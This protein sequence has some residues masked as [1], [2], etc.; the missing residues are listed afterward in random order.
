MPL[1]LPRL[2]PLYAK[3]GYETPA[4]TIQTRLAGAEKAATLTL[5]E[6]R[7]VIETAIGLPPTA[8]SLRPFRDKIGDLT[9]DAAPAA[10]ETRLLAAVTTLEAIRTNAASARL[11]VIVGAALFGGS[12]SPTE[13]P[14]FRELVESELARHQQTN[15]AVINALD[16]AG[17]FDVPKGFKPVQE[18]ADTGSPQALATA[19]SPVL[20][21]LVKHAGDVDERQRQQINLIGQRVEA[22]SE[23]MEMQWWVANGYSHGQTQLF[24][25][26]TVA[27]AVAHAAFDL[28]GMTRRPAGVFAAPTLLSRA[29]GPKHSQ[30]KVKLKELA[31]GV[32]IEQRK[33]WLSSVANIVPLLPV[34][35]SMRLALDA[36]DAADWEGR[37][38]REAKVEVDVQ[39]NAAEWANQMYLELMAARALG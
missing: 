37:L 33:A 6:L 34:L 5:A 14:Q 1:D 36:N 26:M 19:L 7:P 35:H 2:G 32:P 15:T 13:D 10:P 27:E 38:A 20:A 30:K 39:L 21:S 9:F 22:L 11:A 16:R 4:T 24:T 25:D 12:R 23:Q 31:T 28:R 3:L 29:L 18:A 17:A 8:D